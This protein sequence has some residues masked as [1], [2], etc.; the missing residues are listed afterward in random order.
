MSVF[1][2]E[3]GMAGTFLQH[4]LFGT[5]LK[6]KND[7]ALTPKDDRFVRFCEGVRLRQEGK[8]EEGEG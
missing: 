7:R 1:L 3:A 6:L 8:P 4:P 2:G 5:M